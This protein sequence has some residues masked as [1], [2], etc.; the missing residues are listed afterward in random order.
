MVVILLD[1]GSISG[2]AINSKDKLLFSLFLKSCIGQIA[3]DGSG[4]ITTVAGTGTGA[5]SGDGGLATSAQLNTP[6]GIAVD[7]MDNVYFADSNNHRIRKISTNGIITTV[8]GTGTGA[9]SG[10]G[11]LA[12]SA[13]LNTPIGIAV[14][15]LGN[16]VC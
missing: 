15:S 2:I 8:A 11:G 12:T 14:D 6:I 3:K 7:S 5:F 16:V 1:I 4:S 10:D 13:Q 9:F